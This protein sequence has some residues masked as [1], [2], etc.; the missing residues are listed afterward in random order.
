LPLFVGVRALMGMAGVL[1]RGDPRRRQRPRAARPPGRALNLASLS[2]YLG[3]VRPAAGRVALGSG[4]YAA[5]WVVAAVLT[6][7]RRCSSCP[8]PRPRGGRGGDRQAVRTRL[9]HPAAVF[10]GVLVL[11]GAFGMA[12][13]LAFLPLSPARSGSTRRDPA[14]DHA[15]L[16]V[17]LR[18][19]FAKLPDTMGA[20]RLS[21]ARARRGGGRPRPVGA[22]AHADRP[23]GGTVV[24]DRGGVLFPALLALAVGRVDETER[25][26]AVGTT[27]VF[28]DASFGVAGDAGAFGQAWGSARRSSSGPRWRR[29]AR[30]CCSPDA[31]RWRWRARCPTSARP[32]SSAS[33]PTG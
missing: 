14:R 19:R 32:A 23:R 29:W 12:G 20:D 3:R 10:P 9:I 16:V 25:G 17:V 15:L 22:R 28:L 26:S 1:L 8:S 31:P 18:I 33:Q 4:G 6:A 30:G 27:S 7:S 11:C 13:F 21:G 24:R 2:L 5:V